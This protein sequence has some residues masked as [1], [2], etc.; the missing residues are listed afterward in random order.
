MKKR[1]VKEESWKLLFQIYLMSDFIG[2]FN[3]S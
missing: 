2:Y 3:P 1:F